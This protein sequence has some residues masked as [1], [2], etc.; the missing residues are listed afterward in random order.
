MQGL[1]NPCLRALVT[2]GSGVL[3]RALT[4][5]LRERGLAVRVFDLTPP[6]PSQSGVEFV[7]GNVTDPAAVVEACRGCSVVFHLAGRMPQARLSEGGF[8]AV[9][10]DGTRHV[11]DGCVRS[12]IPVLVFAS[13]MLHLYHSN[14]GYYI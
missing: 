10:V 11:A 12:G 9:N 8:R 1:L 5:A 14:T 13:T 7:R 6:L 3:G 2:G 4:R